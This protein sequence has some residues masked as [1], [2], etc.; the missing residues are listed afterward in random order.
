M[1]RNWPICIIGG[2][3]AGCAAALGAG[4]QPDK[5]LL[6]EAKSPWREK[7]CGDAITN[8]GMAALQKL[9]VTVEDLL[10]LGGKPFERTG[11]YA[12]NTKL[13][14]YCGDCAT[15][16]V[17]RRNKFDQLL[18]DRASSCCTLVYDAS[19]RAVERDAQGFALTVASAAA[20]SM[21]SGAGLSYSRRARATSSP[22]PWLCPGTPERPQ[23]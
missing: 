3:P 5:A 9:G 23:R 20:T 11:I 14:E 15:G 10:D 13:L 16:C 12:R 1:S 8:S 17:V 7:P 2:G 22:E 19:V 18:R 4:L 6:L 21:S